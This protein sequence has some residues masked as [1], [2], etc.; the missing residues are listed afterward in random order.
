MRK[1]GIARHNM[2]TREQGRR[3]FLREIST[4]EGSRR[5]REIAGYS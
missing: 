4:E 3:C 1:G 5:I 2:L